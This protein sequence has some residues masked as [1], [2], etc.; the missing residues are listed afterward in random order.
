MAYE[1]RAEMA[2]AVW[3][4]KVSPGDQLAVGDEIAVL[5]VMK[6]EIPVTTPVAGTVASVFVAEQETVGEG[7]VLAVIDE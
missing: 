2:G 7:Q 3:R 6:L 5:E 1:V 4:M